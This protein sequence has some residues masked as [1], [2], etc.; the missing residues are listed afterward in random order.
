[1]TRALM[2]FD[3]GPGYKNPVA[4]EGWNETARRRAEIFESKGLDAL[5]QRAE[6]RTSTHRSAA[7]L[8]RVA[9]G[10]LAQVDSRVIESFE[11]VSV[12]TLIL[13]GEKD[14]PFI[15][16]SQYMAKKV[17]NS[18][19]VVIPG[20]PRRQPRPARRIQRRRR[21]I[22]R[23]AVV[24]QTRALSAARGPVTRYGCHSLSVADGHALP[25][26]SRF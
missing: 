6:V 22:P 24:R 17:P 11:G 2:L 13:V 20:R 23:E 15:N 21:T 16:A 25:H 1:M 12:P 7:G 3:T 4:R 18:T 14:E 8:A 10:M 5:G 19:Y 9:R 26:G